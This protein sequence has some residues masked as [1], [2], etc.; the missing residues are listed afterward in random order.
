M[1]T[2]VETKERQAAPEFKDSRLVSSIYALTGTMM[3]GNCK[4][5]FHT[6]YCWQC[7][8]WNHRRGSQK[9]MWF[10]SLSGLDAT[11]RQQKKSGLCPSHTNKCYF[12]PRTR[13]HVHIT[14]STTA[15]HATI[16]SLE[17]YSHLFHRY[18]KEQMCHF[19]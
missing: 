4:I 1:T 16:K 7:F 8:R 15:E 6:L 19:P 18:T 3:F 17:I 2:T 5:H 11:R 9:E 13:G 10:S 14:V 12:K